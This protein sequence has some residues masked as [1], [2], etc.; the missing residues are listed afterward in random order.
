MLLHRSSRPRLQVGFPK[1]TEKE[2]HKQDEE[3]GAPSVVHWK[4]IQLGTI[5]LWVQ[6]LSLL[7][8]LRIWHCHELWCRSQMWLGS[9]V[10]VAVP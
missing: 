9:D 6:A 4:Q 2:K 1:L 5:R 3:A 8:G 10:A 7:S